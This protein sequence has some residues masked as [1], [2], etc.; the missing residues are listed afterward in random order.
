MNLIFSGMVAMGLGSVYVFL[1][2]P[3][4]YLYHQIYD[5]WKPECC[6]GGPFKF[7]WFVIALSVRLAHFMGYGLIGDLAGLLFPK[8]ELPRCARRILSGL[9]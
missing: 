6:P 5:H 2:L 1:L 7:S 8:R 3:R 9:C 4:L